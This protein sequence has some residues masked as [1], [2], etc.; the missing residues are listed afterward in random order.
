MPVPVFSAVKVKGQK[1][2]EYQRRGQDVAP[3][4][5]QMVFYDVRVKDIKSETVGGCSGLPKRQLCASLGVL[6][7]RAVGD[8]GLFRKLN[9]P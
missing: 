7:W 4:L 9:P 2:Y 3:P 8:R 5:R 1:L 6:Y